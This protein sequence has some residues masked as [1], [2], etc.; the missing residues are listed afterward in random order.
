M[1]KI[2]AFALLLCAYTLSAQTEFPQKIENI[3][4]VS[5]TKEWYQKQ[6]VLWKKEIQ[7]NSNDEN[8][9]KNH[10]TALHYAVGLC[11]G[12]EQTIAKK[13]RSEALNNLIETMPTSPTRYVMEY[14]IKG[15]GD[16]DCIKISPKVFET[17]KNNLHR[18]E[19]YDKY[20]A[21]LLM[22]HPEEEPLIADICKRWYKSGDF[23]SGMLNHFYNELAGLPQN[24]VIFTTG[25]TPTYAYLMLQHAKGLFA[26]IVTVNTPLLYVEKYRNYICQKLGIEPIVVGY[27]NE[28]GKYI[29]NEEACLYIIEQCK[30][31]AY[32]ASTSKLPSFTDKLYCEGLVFRY[33]TT[34]YDNTAV[35]K[36]NF[37]EIYLLDYLKEDFSYEYPL[38][39]RIKM[40]Y[41]TAFKSLLRYYKERGKQS[42]YKRLYSLLQGIVSKNRAIDELTKKYYYEHELNE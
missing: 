9:W 21:Y 3:V 18:L 28:K 17:V 8:A 23:S 14:Y 32:Y 30:R 26:N 35:K 7:K 15:T 6:A 37:E 31:P 19:F 40:N 24:A 36:R 12:D 25:D 38:Y 5:E 42:E 4:K 16:S 27:D 13:R 39:E 1:R 2:I 33:S 29:S 11:E 41:V 22:E 34:T 10:L 20:V